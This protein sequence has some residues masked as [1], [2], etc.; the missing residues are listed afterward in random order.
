MMAALT[1]RAENSTL[2]PS[3]ASLSSS[4][5]RRASSRRPMR[6]SVS[7][8]TRL[9]R[10]KTRLLWIRP[11]QSWLEISLHPQILSR[12]TCRANLSHPVSKL[13]LQNLKLLSGAIEPPPKTTRKKPV[14]PAKR[15]ALPCC[16]ATSHPT[17]SLRASRSCPPGLLRSLAR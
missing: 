3:Q 11:T 5:P 9:T 17:G 10:P 12:L 7:T 6:R 13:T 8:G 15:S 2:M 4:T 14:S 16:P 1:P